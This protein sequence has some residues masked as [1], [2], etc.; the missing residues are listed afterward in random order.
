MCETCTTNIHAFVHWEYLYSKFVLYVC[1]NL[2]TGK[3]TITVQYVENHFADTYNPTIENTFHKLIKHQGEDYLTEIV[4]TAGLVFLLLLILYTLFHAIHNILYAH[5]FISSC[6]LSCRM[7]FQFS[8][9][10]IAQEFMDIFLFIVLHQ[11]LH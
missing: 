10:D 2:H 6:L 5:L 11:S 8:L 1:A 9:K 3:S 7:N 4:D